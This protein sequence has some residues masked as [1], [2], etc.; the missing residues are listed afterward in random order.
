M[1]T[2][3]MT[4]IFLG[5]GSNLGDR[6]DAL[7]QACALL[8]AQ[9]DIAACSPV[10]ETAPMHLAEQPNFLNMAVMGQ[11]ML[12]PTELL[13]ITQDIER[14]VGRVPSVR[15]GPRRID[16]DILLFGLAIIESETLVIPHPRLLERRF[17]LAPLADL[18]PQFKPPKQSQTLHSLLADLPTDEFIVHRVADPFDFRRS[19]RN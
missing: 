14:Q 13:S 3:E 1:A 7:R 9:L 6:M 19:F 11:T 18:A 12:A 4:T 17:A 10:Y 15:F 2:S 16:I 8:A 5:L